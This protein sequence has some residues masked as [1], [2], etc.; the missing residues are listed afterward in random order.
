M[1]SKMWDHAEHVDTLIMGAGLSGIGLAYYMKRDCP[2]KTFAILEARERSGGTWDLFRYPGIR[3]DSDLFTFGYE[4]KPWEDKKSIADG[5]SILSYIRETAAEHNIDQHIRYQQ[6]V[7]RANWCSEKSIWEVTI[8]DTALEG[9]LPKYLTCRWLFS[10]AGY[11]N[12]D[13]GYTPDLPNLNAFA[14]QVIHPQHWPEN[15]DYKDKKV[16]IIGSGATAVTLLPAMANETSHITMLQRT[17]SYIMSMPQQDV[18]ANLLRKLLPSKLAYRLTR[19]KNIKIARAVW[20]FCKKFPTLARKI[21]RSSN[22]RAL[23]KNFPIDTH[24]NPPYNPWDQRLCAVPDGD[25]FKA[26]DQGKGSVVTDHIESFVPNGIALKSGNTLEADIV[27]TATGLDVQ[28]FGGIEL[29]IDDQPIDLS[30]TVAFKGMMLSGIP[31]F[32]F[33]IGYTNSSWTLKVGLLCEHF[34]R[35]LNFMDQ[36]DHTSCRAELPAPNMPTRP[37]LDFGAGYVKRV[38]DQLPRQGFDAPWYMSMDYNVDLKNLRE[39]PITDSNLV[40]DKQQIQP[41]PEIENSA[42]SMTPMRKAS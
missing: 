40:F 42:P 24:F 7:V 18:I 35:L 34:C 17:P 4:F 36:S 38:I 13:A 5:Q 19:K 10:A 12:Y 29:R 31:N 27:I 33:A 21:I 26:I 14:G 1:T 8:Q 30:K 23:P 39:G 41:K 37:L 15:I 9:S 22:K 11:Y 25:L 6:K 3:S 32:A 2:E 16:V 20:R 28:L